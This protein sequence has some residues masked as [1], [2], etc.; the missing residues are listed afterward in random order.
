MYLFNHDVV[1]VAALLQKES[2]K[3]MT[4]EE[5][6]KDLEERRARRKDDMIK[7]ELEVR[8]RVLREG[9][10]QEEYDPFKYDRF[11]YDPFKYDQGG[12]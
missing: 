12:T 10:S 11:K 9:H 5:K 7:E 4:K 6:L 1:V 2:N 8:V 3:P